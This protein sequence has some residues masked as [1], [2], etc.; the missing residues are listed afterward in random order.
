M[1]EKSAVPGKARVPVY[2]LSAGRFSGPAP[3]VVTWEG[4]L[5]F[6]YQGQGC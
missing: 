6:E 5:W 4:G 2:S 1:V 3:L